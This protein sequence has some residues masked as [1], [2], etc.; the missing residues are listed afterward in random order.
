M[1]TSKEKDGPWLN[2]RKSGTVYYTLNGIRVA[3]GIGKSN[4]APTLQQRTARQATAV[5]S[6]FLSEV[7]HY[8]KIGFEVMGKATRTNPQNQAFSYN[9]KNAV[10][11]TYP[12]VTIVY[13]MVLL[14]MGPKPMPADLQ[15]AIEG[16][17]LVLTWNPDVNIP[18]ALWDDQVIVLAYFPEIKNSVFLSGGAK[19]F[20]GL[21]KIPLGGIK[22]GYGL[23]VFFSMISN[24]R[25]RISNSQYLGQLYW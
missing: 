19:R 6:K 12:D 11:G 13:S 20:Q 15:A 10:Q 8:V 16:D 18:D 7:M 21:E 2:G 5:T 14:S 4:K 22:R 25:S 17:L 1:A 3:R 9:R 24:D 23:H